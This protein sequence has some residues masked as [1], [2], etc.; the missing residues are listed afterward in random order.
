MGATLFYIPADHISNLNVRHDASLRPAEGAAASPL[1]AR[2]IKVVFEPRL[3]RKHEDCNGFS[4]RGSSMNEEAPF[5]LLGYFV[6]VCSPSPH[7]QRTEC[8]R[9]GSKSTEKADTDQCD[10][11]VTWEPS[12]IITMPP[13]S[14]PPASL[15]TL[16][17]FKEIKESKR[18]N[19][20]SVRTF[21]Y[22]LWVKY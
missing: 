6:T 5:E 7:A 2:G 15:K 17:F 9:R 22:L 16:F 1:K 3:R 4:R 18:Q 13:E 11:P 12:H 14:C 20:S 10:C 19:A 21:A 8:P